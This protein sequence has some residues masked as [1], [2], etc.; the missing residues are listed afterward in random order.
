M[1]R[2]PRAVGGSILLALL[3]LVAA[4][5]WNRRTPAVPNPNG[6]DRLLELAANVPVFEL[7]RVRTNPTR[8]TELVQSQPRLV[9][10]VVAANQLPSAV[11]VRYSDSQLGGRMNAA[12]DLR[13]LEKAIVAHALLAELERRPADGVTARL[14]GIQIGQNGTR[15]GLMVDFMVGSAIQIYGLAGLSNQVRNLD[16]DT[17][18]RALNSLRTLRDAQEPLSQFERRERRWMLYASG[19]W[20]DFGTARELLTSWKRPAENVSLFG[21]PAGR[22][23]DLQKAYRETEAALETRLREWGREEPSGKR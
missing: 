11:P 12:A 2:A 3:A 16:A 23:R 18:Q 4:V 15:G 14:A 21:T 22:H 1:K 10:E 9:T 5:L 7:D 8:L 13:R 6:Y 19:W 20:R 17:C